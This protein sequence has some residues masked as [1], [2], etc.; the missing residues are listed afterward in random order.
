MPLTELKVRNAKAAAKPVKMTEGNGMHLL[1]APYG[2]KYW[3]F[4][5][6]FGSK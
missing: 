5:Y 4:Q 6:R 3:R 2:S 1:I